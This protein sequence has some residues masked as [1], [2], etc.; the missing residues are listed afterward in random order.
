M[1]FGI[2]F[3]QTRTK[4]GQITLDVNMSETI[5]LPGEVTRYPVEDGS[6]MSDHIFIKAKTLAIEGKVGNAK[7]G[8]LDIVAGAGFFT[9]KMLDVLDQIEALRDQRVTFDVTTG[10]GLYQNMA[11]E[12]VEMSRTADDSGWLN[13]SMKMVQVVKVELRTAEVPAE[14]TGSTA[15]PSGRN[16]PN[17]SGS[18]TRPAGSVTGRGAEQYGPPAPQN[19][20]LYGMARTAIGGAAQ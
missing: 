20:A 7:F 3:L 13:I 1:N 16:T 14:R 18:S 12:D 6:E 5:N 4:V 17:A 11:F 8:L 2:S 15:T 10:L 9:S 19:S